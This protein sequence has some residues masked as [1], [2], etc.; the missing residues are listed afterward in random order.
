MLQPVAT[1]WNTVAELVSRA[2]QLRDALNLLVNFEQHNKKGSR[3]M[4]LSRFKLSK[5]EWE[6]LTQLH[7]MLEVI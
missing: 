7:P 3:G 6:L 4:R 2:L 1:R 5:I